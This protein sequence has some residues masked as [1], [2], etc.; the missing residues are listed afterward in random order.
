MAQVC[1]R[2]PGDHRSGEAG[3]DVRL[4]SGNL[5][6][7]ACQ[8]RAGQPPELGTADRQLTVAISASPP[9]ALAA[10]PHR[11]RVG[12]TCCVSLPG[13]EPGQPR[14][15]CWRGRCPLPSGS[16]SAR[17]SVEPGAG[18]IPGAFPRPF[19]RPSASRTGPARDCERL[20]VT[21]VVGTGLRS[22]HD[23]LLKPG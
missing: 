7:F 12:A 6:P 23:F 18:R 14:R 17:G 4:T 2:P 21:L 3:F 13:S 22:L 1:W 16:G 11:P 20:S 5:R 15:R 8:P 10:P 19:D 9:P